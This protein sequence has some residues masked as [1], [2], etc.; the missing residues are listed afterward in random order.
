MIG[1]VMIIACLV[2]M[3]LLGSIHL[4]YTFFT[5]KFYP[6]NNALLTGLQ[7]TSPNISPKTTL[8]K[9]IIG[10]NASHSMGLIMFGLI[11]GYLVINHFELVLNSVFLQLLGLF[12]LFSYLALAKK[13]WFKTPLLGI[14]LAT[15]FYMAGF[16][17]SYN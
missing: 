10:F 6:R 3:L 8:W 16:A 9:G 15:V 2:I 17:L 14:T 13:Y 11:Y 5:D 12:V 4:F 1:Q 7:T